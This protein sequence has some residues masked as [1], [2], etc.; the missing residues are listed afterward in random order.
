MVISVAIQGTTL[1]FVA[2]LF[3]IKDNDSS[4]YVEPDI[5][6]MEF[7]EEKLIKLRVQVGS[8]FHNK[9]IID[10]KLPKGVLL[11]LIERGNEKI[12]PKGNTKILERDSLLI[13]GEDQI[14]LE[15]LIKEWGKVE[16]E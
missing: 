3:K 13:F 5:E 16:K 14:K 6:Q 15:Q 4:K 2:S 10:M 12:F 8:S 7:L 1:P 11:L 9:S